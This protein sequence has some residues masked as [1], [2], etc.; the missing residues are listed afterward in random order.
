MNERQRI[1]QKTNK[2]FDGLETNLQTRDQ[3][4]PKTGKVTRSYYDFAST[5]SYALSSTTRY[6][7]FTKWAAV[8]SNIFM[9]NVYSDPNR[10]FKYYEDYLKIIE[11]KEIA[12]AKQFLKS[13]R[14]QVTSDPRK[15]MLLF[16]D[17]ALNEELQ[18]VNISPELLQ[19]AMEYYIGKTL[20]T[21]NVS[22]IGS[23]KYTNFFDAVQKSGN[24]DKYERIASF[25][26]KNGVSLKNGM[27]SPGVKMII[28]MF[29]DPQIILASD[30]IPSIYG[31]GGTL[32]EPILGLMTV[33]ALIRLS[34]R[35]ASF[36]ELE[37]KDFVKTHMGSIAAE[38]EEFIPKVLED[39]RKG[40]LWPGDSSL[41]K[42]DYRIQF[43]GFDFKIDIKNPQANRKTG[44]IDKLIYQVNSPTIKINSIINGDLSSLSN[45]TDEEKDIL[46]KSTNY[47]LQSLALLGKLEKPSAQG[48][49]SEIVRPLLIALVT[50]KESADSFLTEKNIKQRSNIV[51]IGTH[52]YFFSDIYKSIL[53]TYLKP[54]KDTNKPINDARTLTID[55]K[56]VA[57]SLNKS[58]EQLL[59]T[60]RSLVKQY[61]KSSFEQRLHKFYDDKNF[62]DLIEKFQ[63]ALGSVSLYVR[64]TLNLKDLYK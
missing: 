42:T 36:E 49:I 24:S 30:K 8:Y 11:P 7:D 34:K 27:S 48:I 15:R 35:A 62:T 54:D 9:S 46:K 43:S 3:N 21:N 12:E 32:A 53:R 14:I 40:T 59:T 41:G 37:L 2:Y 44:L 1:I 39:V 20:K 60:K 4:A 45:M 61:N 6:A 13:M 57:S 63:T 31:L 26:Q 29:N 56:D 51:L 38:A 16:L 64:F 10:F 55:S 58:K 22:K 47:I 28:D 23:S 17:R 33:R 52:F 18:E 19:E 25:I 5:K 50:S